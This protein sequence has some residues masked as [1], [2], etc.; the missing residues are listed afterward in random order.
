VAEE[1][2]IVTVGP[3]DVLKVRRGVGNAHV[4]ALPWAVAQGLSDARAGAIAF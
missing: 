4:C 1:G 2:A 3:I